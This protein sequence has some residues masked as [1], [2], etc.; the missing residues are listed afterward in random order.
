MF[1]YV[2]TVN[3]FDSI[4]YPIIGNGK[5]YSLGNVPDESEIT[6]T[7]EIVKWIVKR[8]TEKN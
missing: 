2:L 6:A 3:I 7:F 5:G 4:I 1:F 8:K